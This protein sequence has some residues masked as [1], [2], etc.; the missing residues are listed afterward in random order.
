MSCESVRKRLVDL[1]EGLLAADDA[2]EVRAHLESCAA[3]RG[4]LE[5][6]AAL[7]RRLETFAASNGDTPASDAGAATMVGELTMLRIAGRSPDRARS[8]AQRRAWRWGGSLAAAACL[9]V[10]VTLMLFTPQ[11]AEVITLAQMS[12]NVRKAGSVALTFKMEMDGMTDTRTVVMEGRLTASGKLVR[13]EMDNA[14]N[15]NGRVIMIGDTESGTVLMLEPR[16]KQARRETFKQ[17]AEFAKVYQ[18]FIDLGKLSGKVVGEEIVRGEAARIVRAD[19]SAGLLQDQGETKLPPGSTVDQRVW[20]GVASGLPVRVEI[21]LSVPG[22]DGKTLKMVMTYSEFQ[23]N[24]AYDPS[25][26]SMDPPQGYHVEGQAMEPRAALE[27]ATARARTLTRAV[28][29]Y[30]GAHLHWPSN[31]AQV[32][33]VDFEGVGA[34]THDPRIAGKDDEFLY[35]RPVDSMLS[36]EGVLFEPGREG[37]TWPGSGLVGYLDGRV[38]EVTDRVR[39]GAMLQRARA[40]AKSPR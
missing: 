8:P 27:L 17:Q 25:F 4:A 11:H 38:E 22:S 23:F 5:E 10:A 15:K 30:H 31:L 37:D 13:S 36:D 40:R 12:E 39:Y 33:T 32:V 29:T 6:V 34:A 9:C 14:F 19:Q 18:R 26:F 7:H 3:C 2:P 1:Q 28:K 20:I 16:T 35:Y 21:T 24:V